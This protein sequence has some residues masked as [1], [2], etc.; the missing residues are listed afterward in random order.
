MKRTVSLRAMIEEVE[1]ELGQRKAVYARI[2]AAHPKR[3]SELEFHMKRMEAVRDYLTECLR[4]EN[5]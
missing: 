1:Y 4:A 5:G 3:K 2:G